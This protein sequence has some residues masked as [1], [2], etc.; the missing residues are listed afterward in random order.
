MCIKLLLIVLSL[1]ARYQPLFPGYRECRQLPEARCLA[2]SAPPRQLLAFTVDAA[3]DTVDCQ[4]DVEP[5]AL[6]QDG[7]DVGSR[8]SATSCHEWSPD[9][10]EQRLDRLAEL[11]AQVARLEA[12]LGELMA[13][14]QARRSLPCGLKNP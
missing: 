1:A 8:C 4:P 10:V 3:C 7:D 6:R 5:C 2:F 14:K 13:E 11:D 12:L 9:E